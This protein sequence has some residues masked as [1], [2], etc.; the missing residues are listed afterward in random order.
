MRI[1]SLRK[2][3]DLGKWKAMQVLRFFF[4]QINSY[5]CKDL[6]LYDYVTI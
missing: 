5:L 6:L 2:R 1:N 3:V 4:Y